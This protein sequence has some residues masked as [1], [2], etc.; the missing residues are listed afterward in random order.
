MKLLEK[1]GLVKPKPQMTL[2]AIVYRADGTVEELGVI[3]S[4]D[5]TFETRNDG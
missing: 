1:L 4:G 2:S 5:V 3:S